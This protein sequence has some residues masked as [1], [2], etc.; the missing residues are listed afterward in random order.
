MIDIGLIGLDTSH[1]EAFARLLAARDDAT[2]S[3]VWDDGTV[4]DDDYVRRFCDEH[5]ATRYDDPT[6]MIGDVDAVMVLTVDWNTHRPLAVPFLEAGVPTFIDKPIAGRA[7]DVEAL[8]AAAEGTSLFG[9]SAIPFHPRLADFPTDRTDGTV[10]CAGYNDPFYYGVHL[11]DTVRTLAADDW[12]VVTPQ[13]R[14]DAVVDIEFRNGSRATLQ[15]DGPDDD[16]AFGILDVRDRTRTARIG[17]D[18]DEYDRMYDRFIDAFLETIRGER[19]DNA[20]LLDAASLLL[21][22]GTAL[23]TGEAVTPTTGVLEEFH[24]DGEEF[25]DDYAPYA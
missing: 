16:A 10:Y 18:A 6:G 8:A 9:G 3:A 1:P 14:S 12:A 13:D 2:V 15:L 25:L 5:G 22:V 23:E 24:V 4:R 21:A 17:V 20:R 7:E 11:T 19:D